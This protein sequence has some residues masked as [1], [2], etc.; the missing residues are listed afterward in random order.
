MSR[1]VWPHMFTLRAAGFSANP[2][3]T[4][5]VRTSNAVALRWATTD[6]L[7]FPREPFQVYRRPRQ[8]RDATALPPLMAKAAIAT[9][10][11]TFT[12]RP[13]GEPAY[14]VV[15]TVTLTAASSALL[16]VL[17]VSGQAIPSQSVT[18]TASGVAEF[19][20]PGIAALRISGSGSGSVG[21]VNA[22]GQSAY[23][24]LAGWTQI[25]TVGLPLLNGEVGTHYRTNPQGVWPTPTQAPTLDGVTAAI[26][27]VGIAASLQ[28]PPPATGIADFPLQAW[29]APVAAAYVANIRGMTP[30]QAID[31]ASHAVT[32]ITVGA[33]PLSAAVNPTTQTIYVAN[34]GSNSVLVING[35]S[36]AVTATVT[37]GTNP[38]GVAVNPQTNKI[39]VANFQSNNVT[40]INGAGNS[41]LA[42]PAGIRPVAVAVNPVT[43][44]IYVANQ[45]SNTVSVI[46]GATNTAAATVNL[47]TAPIAIAVNSVTNK[48]YVANYASGSVTV[49]DG[50]TNATTTV[51]AGSNPISLAVNTATNKI[52]VASQGSGNLTVIDGASNATSTLSAGGS[53]AGVAV[54]SVT[55]KIYV[56]D[57]SSNNLI[58]VDGATHAIST[59]NT[60]GAVLSVAVNPTANKIYVS[61]AASGNL[62]PMIEHCLQNSDD[63][64]SGSIQ[65]LY[66]E[67]VTVDGTRQAGVAASADATNPTTVSL[68]VT[69]AAMMMVSTDSYAAVSLG[70]GT[71][72]MS[73]DLVAPTLAVSV[74]P[75]SASV[76]SGGSQQFTATVTGATNAAVTW[77]VDGIAGGNASVGTITPAGL[78]TAAGR[79]GGALAVVPGIEPGAAMPTPFSTESHTIKAVSV[80]DNTKSATAS[81]TITLALFPAASPITPAAAASASGSPS[82]SAAGTPAGTG[83]VLASPPALVVEPAPLRPTVDNYGDYDYMVTAPFVFPFGLT[84]I[85]AALST[86]QTPVEAPAGLRSAL[87]QVHAPMQRDGRTAAA[88][89]VSWQPSAIPQAYAI[90][91]SRAPSQSEVLNS[92]RPAPVQGFNSFIGL[93]PVNPDPNTPPDQQIPSFTDTACA[94]PLSAPD[95]NNR[96]LVAAQ[97]VFGQWSKWAQTST[98]L[99]AAPVTKLGVRNAE[100]IMDAIHAVGHVV[101]A[102]L[103]IEFGWDWEDRAPGQ[104]RFT[105]HFVASPATTLGTSADLT[106]FALSNTGPLGTPAILTFTY[107]T[108]GPDTIDS[109]SIVPVMATGHTTNGAVQILYAGN[110]LPVNPAQVQYRVDITGFSLD[111]SSTNEIDFLLFATGTEQIRPGIW[112]D[113]TEPSDPY[114]SSN[115][116][117]LSGKIVR[118]MDPVPP[119]VT[120]AP[121]PISWT[122]LPDAT[123]AARGVLQ[124]TADPKAAGYFVWEATESALLQV[125]APNAPDP[126]TKSPPDTLAVRAA[127]LQAV[128][129]ANQD[130]SL[131]GFARLTKDPIPGNRTE[132]V[133]PAST[134]IL[135]VY[136]I[137]AISGANVEAPRSPQI[138]VVGVPRRNVPPI[139]RLMLRSLPAGP[140]IQIVALPVP[141][142]VPPAGYR[143]FRVRS[144]A[145]SHEGSTMGPA[146]ITELPA[147]TDYPTSL[148]GNLLSGHDLTAAQALGQVLPG[149][150]VVDPTAVPSWYPYYYRIKAIGGEDLANGLYSGESD[151]SRMQPGYELPANPPMQASFSLSVSTVWNAALVTIQTDLPAAAPSPVGPALVEVLCTPPAVPPAPLVTNT[152]L[153][154][155]P[156]AIPVGTLSFPPP[157]VGSGPFSL[158]PSMQR[159]A[160]D[161]NGNWVLYIL[162]PYTSADKNLYQIRLTDPLARR[163]TM[164]F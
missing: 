79:S 66:T 163:S 112:S 99:T 39:Y 141:S 71:T 155:A 16:E 27:R 14:L 28:P 123:G 3:T 44:K 132:I 160:P 136:R 43:N 17:D 29:P 121:P 58:V 24:N 34:Q 80:Q 129:N 124:W 30:F 92:A 10:S 89:K 65:S 75:V 95:I 41:T 56:A 15:A 84:Q 109:A 131:Q 97:D 74:L 19:R 111:F 46:D 98:P 31:G 6:L 161:V 90:L 5:G 134:S 70:Y 62:V 23:A 125:L 48:I 159:S 63:T 151:F 120:F 147:W 22:L 33:G 61:G 45:G 145:L 140:G 21:P 113:P 1:F 116:T 53:P 138:A 76:S 144:A 149:K 47:A 36:N 105:G 118:A 68:P 91:A 42:V 127:A 94:L 107:T 106:G 86:G 150:T 152:V 117:R 11:Q 20:C 143:V 137:S 67:T 162:V 52:Y 81:V 73:P 51:S 119:K 133:L 110:T 87:Q 57:S 101:P 72:D 82:L 38:V 126:L 93:A 32:K 115:P 108:P 104:I 50:A 7:G 59:V 77:S 12:I 60:G 122:A 153:S 9:Q 85:F 83:V 35:G 148:T 158:P 88:I 103:R 8:S 25:E 26:Q 142:G 78:F 64:N 54:N 37:A 96:Y 18:L 40:V 69:G 157:P 156:D 2:A 55:N 135:Y 139:P 146:K 13:G 154:S 4:L 128:V 114:N 100:F 164:S 49:I 102:T 130:L